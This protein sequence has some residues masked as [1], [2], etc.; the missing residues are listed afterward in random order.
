MI[1]AESVFSRLCESSVS[2][3]S[4]SIAFLSALPKTEKEMLLVWYFEDVFYG[5]NRIICPDEIATNLMPS[6]PSS[7]FAEEIGQLVPSGYRQALLTWFRFYKYADGS[8]GEE[9]DDR[10][11]KLIANSPTAFLSDWDAVERAGLAPISIGKTCDQ[12]DVSRAV[13]EVGKYN[14]R[15][16]RAYK[17]LLAIL[18]N[19]GQT[20]KPEK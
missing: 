4:A 6:G 20:Q 1:A 9:M 19:S 7:L 18:T 3:L 17:G 16:P 8:F 15:Y 12:E 13:A 11:I 10:T 14:V 2:S 5:Y